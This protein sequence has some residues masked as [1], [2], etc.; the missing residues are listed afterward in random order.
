MYRTEGRVV[1]CEFGVDPCSLT[2]P[3]KLDNFVHV[4]AFDVITRSYDRGGVQVE[5]AITIEVAFV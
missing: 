1:L 2:Y 3:W 4:V 5:R